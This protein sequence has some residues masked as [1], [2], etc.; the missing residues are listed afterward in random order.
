M[1]HRYIG[2]SIRRRE[3]TRLL[4]G[5]GRFVDDI[6]LPD[7][8]HMA[9]YRTPYAHARIRAVHLD[10]ARQL[11]GVVT[12]WSY[13]DIADMASKPFPMF[14]SHPSLKG[15]M[16]QAL[17]SDVAK[18]VGEPIAVVAAA[19]RYVAEDALELIE[20]DFEPLPVIGTLEQAMAPDAP[21]VH[22]DVPGNVA[23][24]FEQTVGDMDKAC[25]T[26]DRVEAL[27]I[28]MQRGC[29]HA[30]ETR[31]VVAQYDTYA[32]ALTLWATIQAP[33]RVRRA[34]AHLLDMP[35]Q[36]IRV[37]APDV[38]GGFGPKAQF[39]PELVLTALMAMRLQ[40]PVKFTEDRR[41]HFLTTS[42][43]R[44]QVHQV[45]VAF[46]R[47]GTIVGLSDTMYID[48]GAYTPA[49]VITPLITQTTVP[50][51]Y[52]IP[53]LQLA[54]TVTFSNRVPMTV[55][56]GAGRS[57]A[58]FVMNRV[59]DHVAR[60]LDLDPADVR[61]RNFI[62]RDEFPFDVG[63]LYR[64]GKP[65]IYDSG[66]YVTCLHKAM[67]I[68]DYPAIRA[69]QAEA[70]QQGRHMGIGMATFVEGGGLGPYEGAVVRVEPGTGKI[71]VHS[72]AGT[73]GQGH[74]TV[75]AQICADVLDVDIDTVYVVT[76]D[77][78]GIGQGMG[79]FGSRVAVLG[80]NAVYVAAQE[81]RDKALRL[82]ANVLQ[83]ETEALSWEDGRV[84]VT[85][86]PSQR[87]S[88]GELAHLADIGMG[89]GMSAPDDN[90]EPA[91]E[92]THYFKAER[93]TYS[94]GIHMV[95]VDVDTD[96]GEVTILRYVIVDDC[97]R[98]L[99]PLLMKGQIL[100]ATA[101]GVSEVL[102][103]ELTY[104]DSGQLLTGTFL[105]YH[106]P[107]AVEMQPVE[108][109][110]VETPSPL[111]PLGSKG[112]GE[113]GIIPAQAAVVNAIED[114]LAHLGVRLYEFPLGPGRLWELIDAQR[115]GTPQEGP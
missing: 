24:H 115:Q 87:R 51:T 99:N 13:A 79:T 31:C 93:A 113:S 63:L 9:V 85:R 105:D 97:G 101:Q 104:D 74:E 96:T 45:Q 30:M 81:V 88:L 43:E 72:G 15:K 80:G 77:T 90:W 2:A 112:A 39:H 22:D 75:M 78:A 66:D 60:A 91:L 23:A 34:L 27:V 73:Q 32:D 65:M 17:V 92:A 11:E 58:V 42:Q 86:D 62:A 7:T 1:S 76:G 71:A 50:G 111:N 57:Q 19:D 56:R 69:E 59:I 95:A 103:E 52:K 110:H 82:A 61:L 94:N 35:Q 40:R 100:G 108:V 28:R 4:T 3:D 37:I 109:G 83:V 70:R 114:A 20:V 64:D 18:Y 26:A 68:F 89:F 49:G 6:E 14:L 46:N 98:V 41:E 55:V 21:L 53:N 8:L 33:H 107:T 12:A 25:S 47:D 106:L 48:M 36:R 84:F 67:E 54:T 10:A 16:Y 29:G 102:Y 44:E 5:R 38:G